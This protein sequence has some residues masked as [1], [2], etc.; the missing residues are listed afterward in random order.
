MFENMKTATIR[1]AVAHAMNAKLEMEKSIEG[2]N[3]KLVVVPR[4][5]ENWLAALRKFELSESD[6]VDILSKMKVGYDASKHSFAVM[7]PISEG[8]ARLLELMAIFEE[9]GKKK[10]KP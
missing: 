7:L 1:Y 9:A 2:D 6:I 8:S 4:D 10:V 3:V 5:V